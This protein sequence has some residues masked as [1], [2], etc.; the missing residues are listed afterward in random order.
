MN[1]KKSYEHRKQSDEINEIFTQFQAHIRGYLIRREIK[2]KIQY[3][4]RQELYKTNAIK[5]QVSFFLDIKYLYNFNTT[6]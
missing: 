3:C 1:M 6:I 5:I 2:N 4:N